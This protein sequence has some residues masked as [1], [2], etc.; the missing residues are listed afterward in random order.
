[1]TLFEVAKI[2]LFRM[3][4]GQL[5]VTLQPLNDVVMCESIAIFRSNRVSNIHIIDIFYSLVV[6]SL[7]DR[8]EYDFY[9]VGFWIISTH[10]LTHIDRCISF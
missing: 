2:D 6:F 7:L 5:T 9:L 3:G 10:G 1:M 4:T 8:I